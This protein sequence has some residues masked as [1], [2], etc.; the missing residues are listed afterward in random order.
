MSCEDTSCDE[1]AKY[2]YLLHWEFLLF[3]PSASSL[4][5]NACRSLPPS[6]LAQAS[7]YT[8]I[9][10]TYTAGHTTSSITHTANPPPLW[11]S[12]TP[13]WALFSRNS[14][15]LF[16]S[17]VIRANGGNCRKLHYS[18]SMTYA[19]RLHHE[20]YGVCNGIIFQMN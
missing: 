15:R 7:G 18:R 6:S 2:L 1:E 5:S 12:S 11:G 4:R 10:H 19:V 9:S 14:N 17:Y 13:V 16:V 3:V 8:N 20:F